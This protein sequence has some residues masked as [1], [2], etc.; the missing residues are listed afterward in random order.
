MKLLKRVP[1]DVA[2]KTTVQGITSEGL[3][4]INPENK[5]M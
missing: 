5:M 1:D 4:D 2:N 3:V